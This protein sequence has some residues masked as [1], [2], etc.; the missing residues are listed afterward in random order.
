VS[1]FAGA[2]VAFSGE[3]IGAGKARSGVNH[4]RVPARLPVKRLV[5]QRTVF[6]SYAKVQS[7]IVSHFEVVLKECAMIIVLSRSRRW[8]RQTTTGYSAQQVSRKG[9]AGKVRDCVLLLRNAGG[10]VTEVESGKRRADADL[11]L[12]SSLP[13]G[14]QE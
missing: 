3:G 13:A 10:Q 4:R 5:D 14:L 11:E 6:P 2:N 9:I 7:E 1:A 12:P 8:N